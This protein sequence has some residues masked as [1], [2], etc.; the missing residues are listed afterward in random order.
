VANAVLVKP[1]QTGTVSAARA[2]VEQALAAGFASVVSARS[3]ETEDSWLAD[4]AVGWRAG[5]IKV[6][7]IMRSER[8][9]KW[10]RLLRVEAET[11]T[12]SPEPKRWLAIDEQRHRGAARMM[13]GRLWSAREKQAVGRAGQDLAPVGLVWRP[14]GEQVQQLAGVALPVGQVRPVRAPDQPVRPR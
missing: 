8:T 9:A 6:G 1:S 10:N 3:G 5:Q 7:S 14:V 2:I 13:R 4:L 12:D 11:D